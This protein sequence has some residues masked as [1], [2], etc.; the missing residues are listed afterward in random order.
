M[1]KK[2]KKAI[3]IDI[4]KNKTFVIVFK[5]LKILYNKNLT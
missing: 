4:K 3:T 5:Y 2:D 1:K